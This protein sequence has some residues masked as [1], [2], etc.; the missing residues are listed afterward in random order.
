M[1]SG[2]SAPPRA[3][4]SYRVCVITVQDVI[5]AYWNLV[6]TRYRLEVAEA[7]RDARH[8]VRRVEP[9]TRFLGDTAQRSLVHGGIEVFG[10][11]CACAG[12]NL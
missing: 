12:R 9:A 3:G 2:H 11:A 7:L 4:D 10:V 5:D 6:A 1:K 8:R